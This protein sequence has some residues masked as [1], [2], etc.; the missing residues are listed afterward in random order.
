MTTFIFLGFIIAWICTLFVFPEFHWFS[1]VFGLIFALICAYN[2]NQEYKRFSI[3][4]T[5]R[6]RHYRY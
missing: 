1:K 2:I 5:K 6:K 3:N 4:P